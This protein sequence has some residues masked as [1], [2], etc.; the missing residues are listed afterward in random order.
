MEICSSDAMDLSAYRISSGRRAY[1]SVLIDRMSSMMR[2]AF[3]TFASSPWRKILLP[4]WATVMPSVSPMI[5]RIF[6]SLP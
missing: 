2:S 6:S 3:R 4:R 5:L 1:P